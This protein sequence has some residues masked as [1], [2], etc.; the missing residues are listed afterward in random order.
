RT[1]DW[2]KLK[3]QEEQEFVIGGWADPRQS[4]TYFGAPLLGVFDDDS[5]RDVGHVG[6]GFDT[7]ELER[8]MRLMRPLEIPKS[9]FSSKVPSNGRQQWM[10]RNV[11]GQVRF[12]EWTADGILRQPV[13]LGLRDDKKAE[14]VTRETVVA[15]AFRPTS[16]K[17]KVRLTA[18]AKA[19]AVK[20]PDTTNL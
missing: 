17:A 13:Y 4:R 10:Q 6:T 11:V 7:R 5:F 2:R 20:K 18:S 3:I 12:T 8:L 19:T 14:T 9:P 16:A 1:P 15:S